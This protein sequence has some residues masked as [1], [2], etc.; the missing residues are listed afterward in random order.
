MG[1]TYAGEGDGRS[2]DGQMMGRADAGTEEQESMERKMRRIKQMDKFLRRKFE[3]PVEKFNMKVVVRGYRKTGKTTLI[4]R[5][6]A[7][8]YSKKYVPTKEIATAHVNWSYKGKS[9]LVVKVEVWDVVDE[10]TKGRAKDVD[11]D[12]EAKR[13]S[14]SIN[15]RGSHTLM[16]LNASTVNVYKGA[17]VVIFMVDPLRRETL[18]YVRKNVD[19][20][21]ARVLIL[22]LL[23]FRDRV[24]AGSLSSKDSTYN[25]GTHVNRSEVEKIL[26]EHRER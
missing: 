12:V 5:L 15:R 21:P 20:V 23:N 11:L 25:H 22:V 6:E 3:R 26:I 17:D 24:S 2:P 19:A 4:R 13:T 7:K 14:E 10:A 1:N 9:D 8:K 18:D 16:P